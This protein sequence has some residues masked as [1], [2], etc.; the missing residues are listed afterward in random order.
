IPILA[1]I[2]FGISRKTVPL[3]RTVQKKTD[4]MVDVLRE[5]IT[6]IR[7]IKALSKSGHEKERFRGVNNELIGSELDAAYT[8]AL[9]SPLMNFVL[10]VGLVGVIIVGA[11]R[12]NEGHIEAGKVIAFL[13]YFS[14]ILNSIIMINRVFI[15]LNQASASAGRIMEV[16]NAEDEQPVMKEADANDTAAAAQD[17]PAQEKLAAPF[18]ANAPYI[19]FENVDFR[20]N[21]T[22]DL[23]LSD[24][25]LEINKGESIGIIGATGCGKTTLVNLLM[26]F[27]DATSGV[28][29][30]E[31]RDVRSI[32]F[33]ELRSRF[34]VAF[35][36]DV[37][38]ADSIY[39][40]ISFCR[41]I[42]LARVEEAAGDAV[43]AGFIEELGIGTDEEKYDY[44]AAIKG[45]NL[46]GGQKQRILV[47]RAL[48]KNPEILILDDSSSALD[49]KT[50]ALLRRNI[51]EHYGETT[52]I[53]V[54]QRI[55]T[56]LHCDKILVMDEGRII[57]AGTHEELLENC[58]IYQEIAALQI[59]KNDI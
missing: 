15:Q 56:I 13:L 22:G 48:A 29:R 4:R 44:K 32:P 45:A 41:E 42:P 9:S 46:S 34:G 55:S 11:W 57:G 43:A 59:D 38:F 19:S 16:I 31:G 50:D 1:L 12:I 7:V 6:G 52:L 27:Y 17:S 53:M 26:R 58:G 47:A 39:E 5:N 21:D 30:I 20:Y 49:Y 54:A 37:I 2:V 28:V 24:I 10:N 40:N 25:N 36:N 8:M 35:Q 18:K 23:C 51:R 33:S 3:Y 14:M